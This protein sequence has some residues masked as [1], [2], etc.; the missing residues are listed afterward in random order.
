MKAAGKLALCSVIT[1]LVLFYVPIVTFHVIMLFDFFGFIKPFTNDYIAA[2][3][4][5]IVKDLPESEEIP[6]PE[7]LLSEATKESL[8]V[9]SKGYVFPVVIR[10]LDHLMLAT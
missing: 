7:L 9:A 4:K 2:Y 6:C 10:G 5:Y 1:I 3:H 8:R